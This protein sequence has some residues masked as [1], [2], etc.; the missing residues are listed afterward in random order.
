MG[1]LWR[2]QEMKLVQLFIQIEAAHDTVDELGKL[3]LI[4]FRDLNPH[5]NA[6]QRNFINEVKRADEMERKLRFFASE[7][8]DHN[9]KVVGTGKTITLTEPKEELMSKFHMDDLESRFDE[10]E[11]QILEQNSHQEVLHRNYNQLVELNHVLEKDEKFFSQAGQKEDETRPLD[12]E[13]GTTGTKGLGFIS[14]VIVRDKFQ[15]FERILFRAARGN[16]FL[17]FK[18]IDE[19]IEDPIDFG[20]LVKKNVFIVFFHGT[21]LQSKI[22]KICESFFCQLVPLPRN[23]TRT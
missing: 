17:K 2:S 14:G 16:I 18:E 13:E 11:K 21:A 5:V 23:T 8:E 19:D 12:I 7:I 20:R 3:G 1:E 10:Y 6:F 9:K 4:E 22:K 15:L